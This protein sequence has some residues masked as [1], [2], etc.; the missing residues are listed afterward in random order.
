MTMTN[1]SGKSQDKDKAPADPLS[2]REQI[3]EREA[4]LVL[5]KPPATE[6]PVPPPPPAPVDPAKAATARRELLELDAHDIR[7]EGAFVAQPQGS[8]P[9]HYMPPSATSVFPSDA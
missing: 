6:P 8:G 4:E 7:R 5:G 2:L 1:P 9:V 3:T